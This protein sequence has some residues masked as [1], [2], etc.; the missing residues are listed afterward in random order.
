MV[1]SVEI[2]YIPT[3]GAM[4][5]QDQ[6][7]PYIPIAVQPR[8]SGNVHAIDGDFSNKD[9]MVQGVFEREIPWIRRLTHFL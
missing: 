4:D 9:V 2:P 7:I 1:D 5:N 3:G 6:A 8:Q